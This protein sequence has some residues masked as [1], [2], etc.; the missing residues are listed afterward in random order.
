ML[1]RLLVLAFAVSSGLFAGP[2]L[3]AQPL[4]CMWGTPYFYQ[5]QYVGCVITECPGGCEYCEAT[6][7]MP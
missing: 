3:Q 1:K 2:R 5:G 6:P 4:H 7:Q